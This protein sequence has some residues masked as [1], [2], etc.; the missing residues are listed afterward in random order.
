V[1]RLNIDI[2]AFTF[3]VYSLLNQEKTVCVLPVLFARG[4]DNDI[5]P[6]CP[7]NSG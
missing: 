7:F 3:F 2:P 1:Y 5:Q 4:A 6:C